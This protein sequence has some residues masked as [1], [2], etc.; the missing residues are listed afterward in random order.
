M[1]ARVVIV[2]DGQ[3]FLNQACDALLRAGY[4][5]IAYVDTLQALIG[6]RQPET[7]DLLIT[8]VKFL[9]QPRGL[10]L[11]AMT[12]SQRPN[13]KVLFTALPEYTNHL[14]GVGAFLVLP[15]TMSDLVG[16]VDQLLRPSN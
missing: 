13:I 5:V 3:E 8:R 12:L 2:H 16:A 9:G 15:V 7:V 10:N 14:E 4:T 6:L 1:S 11:A